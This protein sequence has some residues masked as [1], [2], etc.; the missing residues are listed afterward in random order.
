LPILTVCVPTADFAAAVVYSIRYGFT[1]VDGLL[2]CVMYLVTALGVEGGAPLL[3]PLR[4]RC[5]VVVT[6]LLGVA[7]ACRKPSPRS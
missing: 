2:F 5:R 1:S 3:L 4:V 7:G 6:R